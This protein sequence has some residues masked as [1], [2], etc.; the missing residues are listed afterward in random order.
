MLVPMRKGR[1]SSVEIFTE[2]FK[3]AQLVHM[4]WGIIFRE[5]MHICLDCSYRRILFG[6]SLFDPA[7]KVIHP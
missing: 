4:I 7:S 5:D 6:G 3:Y 2:L 1:Y